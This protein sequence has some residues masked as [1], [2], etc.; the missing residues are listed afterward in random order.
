M[1][2]EP[3]LRPAPGWYPDPHDESQQRWWDG[4][5]WT[6][7]QREAPPPRSTKGLIGA[8]VVWGAAVGAAAGI[9]LGGV[10]QARLSGSAS[11]IVGQ[12]VG[13]G[14][15]AGL[16]AGVIASAVRIRWR[17]WFFPPLVA[18]LWSVIFVVG[19]LDELRSQ[20][21][22]EVPRMSLSAPAE[23]EGLV[24][25]TGPEVEDAQAQAEG[26]LGE[27]VAS[28]VLGAYTIEGEDQTL[29]FTG[30]NLAPGRAM[31]DQT[32]T[33]PATVVSD[34]LAGAGVDDPTYVDD[35]EPG[36]AMMC[37]PA[38]STTPRSTSARGRLRVSWPP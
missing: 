18:V 36:V 8:G 6:E 1:T 33:S 23:V 7:Q 10:A 31:D 35:T 27:D 30:M 16:L 20:P 22:P 13:V 3:A 32:I 14:L 24:R 11:Y 28:L 5:V 4:T 2:T 21:S 29:I 15:M 17:W 38:V 26:E 19:H 9:V 37:G 25:V 12:G 34:A